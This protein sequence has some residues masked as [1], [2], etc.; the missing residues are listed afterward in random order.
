MDSGA[1]RDPRAQLPRL[2]SKSCK[3]LW[4]AEL[5]HH[6]PEQTDPM[7][8]NQAE[9]ILELCI[10]IN[11]ELWGHPFG[12]GSTYGPEMDLCRK[13]NTLGPWDFVFFKDGSKCERRRTGACKGINSIVEFPLQLVEGSEV[14]F[15]VVQAEKPEP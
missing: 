1:Q 7:L 10:V 5:D 9:Q 4:P 3:I 12:Q 6:S 13:V 15:V 8:H 2:Q 11:L 14:G